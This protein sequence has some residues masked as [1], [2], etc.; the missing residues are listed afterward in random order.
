MD[1]HS[2]IS[3]AVRFTWGGKQTSPL[4]NV[5]FL[6]A[7][8]GQRA[9][10]YANRGTL[11]IMLEV[12]QDDLPNIALD[13][14]TLAGIA[15]ATKE[16]YCNPI[17]KDNEAYFRDG[18]EASHKARLQL[19]DTYPAIPP[20][21]AIGNWY[22]TPDWWAVEQVM[23]AVSKD[24]QQPH[25]QCLHF[26]DGVIEATDRMRVAR[27]FLE[28]P[29]RGMVSVDTF[30]NWPKNLDR[31]DVVVADDIAWFRI[32]EEIRLSCLLKGH[33]FPELEGVLPKLYSGPAVA[34]DV[35][36]LTATVKKAAAT[37]AE[38]MAITFNATVQA[39]GI[40]SGG[41]SVGVNCET[42]R[43]PMSMAP[44]TL[45]INSKWMLDALKIC[46]TPKVLLGYGNGLDPL[47]I[48]TGP[49]VEG[50]WP[51]SGG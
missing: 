10:L 39:L 35:D 1:L 34:V 44:V 28:L 4:R 31:V 32:G 50:I 14:D 48:E 38:G 20:V 6:P 37:K 8:E 45:Q 18:L 27:T 23:H 19:L 21:P 24:K 47:R 16:L 3:Q 36:A 40:V 5:R 7:S 25:L 49:F 43:A 26:S 9:R 22:S 2:A 33:G 41:F 30:K 11:G 15:K 13:G 17:L 29:V 46:E 42:V 12:D 51:I